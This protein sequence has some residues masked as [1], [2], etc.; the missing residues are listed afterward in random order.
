[1]ARFSFFRARRRFSF[2]GSRFFS[3][4]VMTGSSSV[5]FWTALTSVRSG[6]RRPKM[7]WKIRNLDGFT[8]E[9]RLAT[10]ESELDGSNSLTMSLSTPTEKARQ[11]I[12][13]VD[14]RAMALIPLVVCRKT[15]STWRWMV[16]GS[17]SVFVSPNW[18]SASALLVSL[19][20]DSEARSHVTT[21]IWLVDDS[22]VGWWDSI[23]AIRC[24]EEHS[25]TVG[26]GREL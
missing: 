12:G 10:P 4:L 17:L 3:P 26:I 5:A 21:G 15:G 13:A 19:L 6:Y 18:F 16:E 9:H 11:R 14:C 2:S 8:E 1:M 22:V 20:D 23:V 25:G 7:G 24:G